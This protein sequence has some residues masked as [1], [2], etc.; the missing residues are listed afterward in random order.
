VTEIELVTNLDGDSDVGTD[1]FGIMVDIEFTKEIEREGGGFA[2]YL[3]NQ[4]NKVNYYYN[5]GR[6]QEDYR[7]KF[8]EAAR[9][10]LG[11]QFEVLSVTFNKEDVKSKPA[12]RDGWRR[13]PYAYILVEAKG[14]EVDR[15]PPLKLDLDFNDVTGYVVLPIA[16][17][18]VPVDASLVRDERP[19]DNVKITQTLDERKSDEGI[20]TLEIKA[21]ANGLVPP[22]DAIM[23]LEVADFD[24]VGEVKDQGVSVNS[25]RTD[26]DGVVTERLWTAEF[27][28]KEDVKAAAMFRF[29]GP[30]EDEVKMTYQRMDDADMVT[31]KQEVNLLAKYGDGSSF[32]WWGWVVAWFVLAALS[33]AGWKFY[34]GRRPEEQEESLELPEDITPFTVIGLLRQ[35]RSAPNLQDNQRN[36]IDNTV[37]RIERFYFGENA[38]GERPDLPN[39]AREW[40]RRA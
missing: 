13:L 32:P 40:L 3:Q 22:L 37:H 33:F 12:D 6:P 25:F 19:F 1:P 11:E 5:Y 28:A 36:E 26:G 15:V 4:S 34:G 20:L 24:L 18:V 31:A 16:S 27:K 21:I 8:E 29:A 30:L 39:I 23:D 17:P 2:K 38:E 7:D 14:P 10:I 9:T 35:V